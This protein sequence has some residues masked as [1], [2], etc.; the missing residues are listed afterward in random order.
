MIGDI[1]EIFEDGFVSSVSAGKDAYNLKE[2]KL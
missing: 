1:K 2:L